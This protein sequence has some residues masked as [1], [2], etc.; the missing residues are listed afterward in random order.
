MR[1]DL[2]D[3]VRGSASGQRE[4]RDRKQHHEQDREALR[5][6]QDAPAPGATTRTFLALG[7]VQTGSGDVRQHLEIT[8]RLAE[9]AG[10]SGSVLLSTSSALIRRV[11]CGLATPWFGPAAGVCSATPTAPPFARAEARRQSC[12][13]PWRCGLRSP[14]GTDSGLIGGS[15][16]GASGSGRSADSGGSARARSWRCVRGSAQAPGGCGWSAGERERRSGRRGYAGRRGVARTDPE[17]VARFGPPGGAARCAQAGA[18]VDPRDPDFR[19]A[20]GGAGP[21]GQPARPR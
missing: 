19:A 7:P 11:E 21:A 8:P 9:C 12:R 10:P 2:V 20:I 6:E 16:V 15:R 18:A 13:P 5:F 4:G 14:P 1:G 17:Q 3:D